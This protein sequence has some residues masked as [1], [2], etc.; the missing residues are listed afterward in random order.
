MELVRSFNLTELLQEAADNGPSINPPKSRVVS[1][2]YK[3]II[4][5]NDN[6]WY[7]L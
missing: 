3:C 7:Y 2:T 5:N 4:L 6:V 1:N